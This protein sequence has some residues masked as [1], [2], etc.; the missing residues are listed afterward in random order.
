MQ[1]HY[2]VKQPD[3]NHKTDSALSQQKQYINHTIYFG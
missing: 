1:L 2:H 3:I